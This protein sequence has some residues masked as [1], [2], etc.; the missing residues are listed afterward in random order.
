MVDA[1]SPAL[2]ACQYD[3]GWVEVASPTEIGP[4]WKSAGFAQTT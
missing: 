2:V 1:P 4:L 3:T